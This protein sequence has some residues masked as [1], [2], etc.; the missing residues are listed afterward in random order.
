MSF[1]P[2]PLSKAGHLQCIV[3]MLKRR[4]PPQMPQD[5]FPIEN[6][7]TEGSHKCDAL[8]A[9]LSTAFRE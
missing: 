1:G 9:L 2:L 8:T 5:I 7:A 4:D 3:L 6:K